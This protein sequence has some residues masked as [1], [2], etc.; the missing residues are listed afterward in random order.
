[1]RSKQSLIAAALMLGSAL[2]AAPSAARAAEGEHPAPAS[3]LVQH[4][5]LLDALAVLA[6]R[7]GQAG[8][9]G[10][11]LLDAMRAYLRYREEVVLPAFVLLPRVADGVASADMAWAIALAD[12]LRRERPQRLL[13]REDITD[14]LIAVHAAAQTAGD[15]AAAQ[16]ARDVAAFMLGDTE[17]DEN[18][19][20]ALSLWLRRSLAAGG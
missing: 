3:A 6:Q 5:R 11:R 15:A 7:P 12:Q 9:E 8:A 13:T 14:R 2:A 19:T 10:Q 4:A 16:G 20:L 1:M 17:A 18:M